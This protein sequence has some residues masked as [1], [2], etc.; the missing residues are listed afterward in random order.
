MTENAF[1]PIFLCR[2]AGGRA[3]GSSGRRSTTTLWVLALIALAYLTRAQALAFGPAILTAPLL[4]VLGAAPRLAG[5]ARLPAD[6]R[7]RRR[8][9]P[10][11]DRRPGRARLVAARRSSAP[12]R[13]RARRTTTSGPVV[14]AGS[15]TSSASSTSRSGSLPFAAL[16]VLVAVARGPG[17]ARAGV[18]RRARCAVTFWL[19]LEVSAF[20]SVHQLRVEER[21]TFYV[22]PLFLIALLVWIDARRAAARAA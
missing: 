18:P 14:R 6:V 1:Y 5:A 16:I 3:S 22:V 4:F 8:R 21:N 15:G 12:T 20:A 13:S 2:G 10:A 7:R 11:R 9:R 19:M 17:P